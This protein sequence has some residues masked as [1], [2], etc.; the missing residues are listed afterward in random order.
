MSIELRWFFINN[1]LGYESD[2]SLTVLLIKSMHSN[3]QKI[4]SFKKAAK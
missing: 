2:E 4:M 3:I 1:A